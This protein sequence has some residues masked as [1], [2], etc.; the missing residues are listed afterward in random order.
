MGG[1]CFD[2]ICPYGKA[3]VDISKEVDDG[4]NE[5]ECSNMGMC[6]RLTGTCM[7]NKEFTGLACSRKSC[8][9]GCS[10]HGQ[11]HS[12]SYHSTQKDPGRGVVYK[13]NDVWDFDMQYGCVCD[14][15]RGGGYTGPDCALRLCPTGDDPLTGMVADTKNGVQFD[16]TQNV[17]CKADG[18]SFTL[19]FRKET[20]SYIQ[21]DDSMAAL[22][23]TFTDLHMVG[24]ATVTYAGITTVACTSIGNIISIV[25]TQD[26]GDVPML[27]VDGTHLTHSSNVENPVL[28]SIELTKGTKEN[29]FC[30][31]RGICDTMTGICTCSANYDTSNGLKKAGDASHNRGDC[32]YPTASITACPGPI[33]CSGHGVCQ[34]PP[35]YR[36]M[37]ASGWQGADCSEMTCVFGSSW[38]DEAAA[39]GTAHQ[40]VE[41][42]N[43]GLCD[44]SK[45]ACECMAGFEG[46]ACER[47][48]CPGTP[49]CFGHGQCKTIQTLA[50][51]YTINGVSPNPI[52]TYGAVPNK[53]QTWDFNKVQGCWCDI[54]YEG[55]DCVQKTCPT[56]ED[57]RTVGNTFETQTLSCVG[58]TGKFSIKFRNQQT[59]NLAF[60]LT[61]T[62]LKAAL[63]KLTNIGA[64][65]IKYTA[66]TAVEKAGGTAAEIAAVNKACT[67]GGTNTVLVKFLT[68]LGDLPALDSVLD[69]VISILVNTDGTGLSVLGTKMN[70]ECSGR[71]MCDYSTGVC[72][73]YAGFSS[74][75][76]AGAEG[77][78][79]DC[80]FVEPYYFGSASEQANTS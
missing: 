73:C 77:T 33:S 69:G 15:F 74:S 41:C 32:G 49:A 13:Y 63:E 29:A 21:Y 80:G 11:C 47:M 3:W 50:E 75:N 22:Q 57:P 60:D 43:M 38:F 12:M 53:R 8:P 17:Y 51:L 42:S 14:V 6:D 70:A 65:E 58:T 27:V 7:C 34:G 79:G 54:G 25:F 62:E 26:F 72:K 67:V 66:K 4:H 52:Y 2:R 18:G 61:E 9:M 48:M 37:C 44:R 16:E 78:R 59:A 19:T 71:G 28:Y 35:T 36:C 64:V 55:Y 68:E 5:A 23:K 56:G 24:D 39:E 45:G 31:D 46:A 20:S 1:D 40:P 10:G 76:G 30:S